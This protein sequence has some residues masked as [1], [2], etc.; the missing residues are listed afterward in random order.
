MNNNLNPVNERVIAPDSGDEEALR[1]YGRQLAI[2]SLM[3]QIV[4]DGQA[5][6]T[7]AAI[8][9]FGQQHWRPKVWIPAAAAALVAFAGISLWKRM[10]QPATQATLD[11]RWELLAASD[12][13]YRIVDPNRVELRKGELRFTSLQP[14]SLVVD[15]PNATST[16]QGTDFLIGHHLAESQPHSPEKHNTNPDNPMKQSTNLTRL[17]VL[18][19]TAILANDQGSLAAGPHE[20]V[21]AQAGDAPQKIL[22][23]ANSSFAFD[24]YAQLA[25]ENPGQ[26]LF[27]SPYSM[28]NA[29]LMVAEG[30]RG[31]TAREMGTVL[32]FPEALRRQGDDSQLIPWEMGKIRVGQSELNRLMNKGGTITL[33]QSKLREEE[34]SLAAKLDEMEKKLVVLDRKGTQ[35][36]EQ[37]KRSDLIHEKDEI[38][39]KL[40]KL[41]SKIDTSKLR[42]ANA[43]WGEQSFPF[44]EDWKATV[45]GSY[46]AGAV[47]LADF[48][49]NAD[50]ERLR[51]NK[52][53]TQQTEGLIKDP[54]P[55]G[56]LN[57]ETRL[58]IVNAIYFK[59]EWK[60]PFKKSDTS[61]QPFTLE[62]GQSVQ[63]AL[64][65]RVDSSDVKYAA[66]HGDGRLFATP[67][68]V[69]A[70][71]LVGD[72]GT[73]YPGKDGF[74]MIEMPYRGDKLSMVVIA[75]NDPAGLPSIESRLNAAN[76][77][78]WMK[79]MAQR[80]IEVF[81]PKFKMETTY[82]KLGEANGTLAAMGMPT[83]FGG[84]ADFSGMGS[85]E[86]LFIDQ[87]IHKAFISV[88]EAGTEA[89]AITGYPPPGAEAPG[90]KI[91]FTPTFSADRPFLYLI[92]DRGSGTVL[93]LGRML[94]PSG[95]VD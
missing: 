42:I 6:D 58:A 53:A 38:A 9:P 66:F 22:M 86:Q 29:L 78:A 85:K 47:Q 71:E 30:A 19:G 72:G 49:T 59:G 12:A 41:R 64:M 95:L 88:N 37:G 62:S 5:K 35:Q 20:A 31:Q 44:N 54:F 55:E 2:D 63:T 76:L 69:E 25:K 75:P 73:L 3:E 7:P 1:E 61:P 84:T 91:P 33:E 34:A 67:E 50:K 89:A 90:K 74:S 45:T 56:S 18:A 32:G 93:F 92:H 17:L 52:W 68:M 14:A 43:I 87:V 24:L 81:M 94:N 15:T 16:A 13:D 10:D 28:S 83:A 77:A 4:L 27:F 57:A 70:S 60:T 39:K 79:S 82:D 26:N 40:E 65:N 80:E 46:G 21:V 36:N 51:I 48:M 8:V 11:P 23:E